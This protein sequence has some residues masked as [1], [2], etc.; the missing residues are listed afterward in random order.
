MTSLKHLGFAACLLLV[1]PASA[2]AQ[3][4]GPEHAWSNGTTIEGFAGAATD[5][6]TTGALAGGGAGWEMTPRFGIAGSMAWLDRGTGAGAFS[7]A[8]TA[9]ASLLSPRGVVPFVTGGFGLYRASFDAVDDSIPDFY[10]PRI[11]AESGPQTTFTFTDPAFVVGGGVNVFASRNWSIRPKVDV[12]I[13]VRDSQSYVVTAAAVGV[14]YH[15]ED[16]PITPAR[17]RQ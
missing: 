14:A 10:R 4:T 6:S 15:F 12:M 13:V 5:S 8:L 11:E 16:H 2:P 7:A 1:R 9:H 3:T 17:K